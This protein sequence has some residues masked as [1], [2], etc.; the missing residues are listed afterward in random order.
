MF[1]F[2][3]LVATI[4]D[5]VFHVQTLFGTYFDITTVMFRSIEFFR[6]RFFKKIFSDE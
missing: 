1:L 6:K 3:I 2:L 4:N 5:K